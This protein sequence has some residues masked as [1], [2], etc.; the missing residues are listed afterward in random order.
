MV[1]MDSAFRDFLT[2]A[3][4]RHSHDD[5]LE[6]FRLHLESIAPSKNVPQWQM[7]SFGQRKFDYGKWMLHW[8]FRP[9]VSEDRKLLSA[10]A[11]LENAKEL[12]LL[13]SQP[14]QE[15]VIIGDDSSSKPTEV[16][17][18]PVP[19]IPPEPP[20]D[21][22]KS[23][24]ENDRLK[25]EIDRLKKENKELH[26]LK[27]ENKLYAESRARANKLHLQLKYEQESH[28]K[29]R[30]DRGRAITQVKVFLQ[31]IKIL[32]EAAKVHAETN[33]E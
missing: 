33:S 29:T 16:P 31:R 25:A 18:E 9:F 4:V 11:D 8:Q 13:E 30:K 2:Q 15:I 3:H 32:E 12:K 20:K 10:L 7:W 5:V 27:A 22:S 26:L 6:V 28:E 21:Q 23:L 14:V 1:E 17:S 19:V 24:A